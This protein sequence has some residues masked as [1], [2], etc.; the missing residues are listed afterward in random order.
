M[1]LLQNPQ[2]LLQRAGGL[3]FKWL[4]VGTGKQGEVKLKVIAAR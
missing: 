4:S 3:L 2:Q 1:H